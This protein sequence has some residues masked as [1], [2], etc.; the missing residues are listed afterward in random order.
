MFIHRYI[1]KHENIYI[2][3]CKYTGVTPPPPAARAFHS[4]GAAGPDATMV[5]PARESFWLTTY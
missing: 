2:H 3:I 4:A 1:Y 5:Y